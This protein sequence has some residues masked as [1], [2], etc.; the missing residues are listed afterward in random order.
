MNRTTHFV[1][2]HGGRVT[3]HSEGIDRRA[4]FEVELRAPSS[5]S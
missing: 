4:C 2:F 5:P 1:E 3:A